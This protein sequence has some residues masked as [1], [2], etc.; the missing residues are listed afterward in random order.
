MK[1]PELTPVQ[2]KWVRAKIDLAEKSGFSTK[3]MEEILAESKAK[4]F[5]EGK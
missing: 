5:K 4:Y 2:I 1:E 3:T